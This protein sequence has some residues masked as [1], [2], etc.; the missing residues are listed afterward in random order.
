[1]KRKEEVETMIAEY[2][3]KIHDRTERIKARKWSM[4]F[5]RET[6]NEMNTLE[7]YINEFFELDKTLT[8]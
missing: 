4:Q 1:M 5:A 7:M 6:I 8:N 3:R 2:A